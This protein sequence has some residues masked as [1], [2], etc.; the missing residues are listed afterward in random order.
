MG[1]ISTLKSGVKTNAYS[2]IHCRQQNCK[3]VKKCVIFKEFQGKLKNVVYCEIR[4]ANL[5][6]G[7]STATD[8]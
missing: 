8:D 3:F 1:L 6:M 5:M 2:S 4:S 7:R